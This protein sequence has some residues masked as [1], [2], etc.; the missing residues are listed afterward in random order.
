MTT[1]LQVTASSDYLSQHQTLF[2]FDLFSN[3]QG[4]QSASPTAGT[5]GTSSRR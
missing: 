1:V 5:A 4:A 2:S 3:V